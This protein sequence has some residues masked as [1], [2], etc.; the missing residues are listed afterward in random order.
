M[1]VITCDRCNKDFYNKSHYNDHINRKTPCTKLK[2]YNYQVD[3]LYC[4]DCGKYFSRPYT[5]SRH[6][7][8]S[9]D[10]CLVTNTTNTIEKGNNNTINYHSGSGNINN[11]VIKQYLFPF[12]KDGIDCLTTPEKIA[13][14]SSDENPMEMIIVK[15]NLDSKKTDHHNVGFTDQHSGYGII[16]DGGK[17]LTERIDIILQILFESKEKDLLKIYDE[18]K[19]FLS[20]DLNGTIKD[21]LDDLNKAIDPRNTI[22]ADAKRNLIA[23]LKKHLYNSRGLAL[24]AKKLTE[25]KARKNIYKG[26]LKDGVTIE[27]IDKSIMMKKTMSKKLDLRKEMAHDLL[28]KLQTNEID[29]KQ[30]FAILNIIN[31]NFN[32]DIIDII[33]RLLIQSYCRGDVINK[34]I[35]DQ[36]IRKEAEINKFIKRR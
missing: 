2:K 32:M 30:Y 17:W 11:I 19:D 33:N 1:T 35:I 16:F 34:N 12:G 4:E 36:A 26:I 10:K 29:K 31:K 6:Q 18:I 7:K 14:F 22:D 23:H 25:L 8:S 21:K 20:D 9:C 27:D 3:G 28:D 5:L 15:V 24:N 13:I